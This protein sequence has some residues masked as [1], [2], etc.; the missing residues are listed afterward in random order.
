V[1]QCAQREVREETGLELVAEA[2]EPWGY[3]RF[4]PVSPGGR[5][6][7]G[8]GVMQVLTATLP[9]ATGALVASEPDAVDPRWVTPAEFGALAEERFWW[10]LVE[11]ALGDRRRTLPAH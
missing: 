6:P 7:P 8:G 11:P 4:T 1:A 5:W 3:E 9:A 2:L 10:P